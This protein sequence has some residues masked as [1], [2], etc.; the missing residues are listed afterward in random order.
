MLTNGTAIV[1]I[2]KEVLSLICEQT[3]W[4]KKNRGKKVIENHLFFIQI[5]LYL[6]MISYLKNVHTKLSWCDWMNTVELSLKVI[7]KSH[8]EQS[9]RELPWISNI[10]LYKQIK[11]L[12]MTIYFKHYFFDNVVFFFCILL[13]L[14]MFSQSTTTNVNKNVIENIRKNIL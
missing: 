10:I 13:L 9:M 3:Y 2:N 14:K 6:F 4:H 5:V 1:N 7:V 11:H 8:T 12:D